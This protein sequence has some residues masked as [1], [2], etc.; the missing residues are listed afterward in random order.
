MSLNPELQAKLN[1]WR[2]KAVEGT[3]SQEE[4]KEAILAIRG[5]RK[6]A[7]AVSD[8][9]RRKKAKAEVKSADDLLGELDKL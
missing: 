1:L 2:A 6:N 5:D 3:L 9:S 4:M 7:A 8:Q